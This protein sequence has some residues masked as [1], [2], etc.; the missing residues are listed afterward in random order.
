MSHLI[1]VRHGESEW[2]ALGRWTGR[3]DIGLTERGRQEARR[4]AQLVRDFSIDVCRCSTLCRARHT[5][6]EIKALCGLAHVETQE[7]GALDERDYGEYTGLNKWEV[8]DAVGEEA[9]QRLR[10]SWDHLVPGGE[11]LRDVHARVVPYFE[12]V[13]R[14]EVAAGRVTLISSHGNTLRALVKHLDAIPDDEIAKLEIATG[15]VYVYRLDAT[16]AVVEKSVRV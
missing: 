10:R 8:R 13:V 15:E 16:G 3:A 5:L 7:H 11:S 9:F 2:N 6:D 12:S 1:L 14:P 4:A